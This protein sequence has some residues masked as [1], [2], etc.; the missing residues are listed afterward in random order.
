MR[1][2]RKNRKVTVRF[3]DKQYKELEKASETLDLSI[4]EFIRT[5]LLLRSKVL[6][7]GLI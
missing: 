1:K 7:G 4:S 2:N 6:Q 3:S 5:Q